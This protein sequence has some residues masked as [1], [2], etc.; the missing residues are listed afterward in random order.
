MTPLSANG[1]TCKIILRIPVSY[2]LSTANIAF[3]MLNAASCKTHYSMLLTFHKLKSRMRSCSRSLAI[4]RFAF[5]TSR[6]KRNP[7]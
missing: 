1:P 5:I 6:H 3:V 2:E 4:K 7:L